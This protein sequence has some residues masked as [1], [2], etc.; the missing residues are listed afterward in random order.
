MNISVEDYIAQCP[1]E[2]Q[3][4]LRIIRQYIQEVAHEATE[5]TD[6]FGL[7][8]YSYEGYDYDGMFAWFSFKK[9]YVRIHVRPPVIQDHESDLSNY[10]KTKSIVSFPVDKDLPEDLI[11]KLVLASIKVMEDKKHSPKE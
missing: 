7:P 8:G 11:K 6:Y 2:A 9:P 5:R 3:T 1:S 10:I 4:K